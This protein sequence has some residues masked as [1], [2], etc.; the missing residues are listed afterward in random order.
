MYRLKL[1]PR[2]SEGRDMNCMS[3]RQHIS[4][5]G[6]DDVRYVIEMTSQGDFELTSEN[7]KLLE[8]IAAKVRMLF[9]AEPVEDMDFPARRVR[10]IPR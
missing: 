9:F 6:V 10:V 1:E 3:L 7:R 2:R 8:A 4:S 5:R